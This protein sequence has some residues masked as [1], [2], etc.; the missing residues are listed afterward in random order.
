MFKEELKIH[1][2]SGSIDHSSKIEMIDEPYYFTRQ[3]KF[4]RAIKKK[5]NEFNDTSSDSNVDRLKNDLN[6]L[7]SIMSTNIDLILNRQKNLD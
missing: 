3:I 6:N 5:I 7:H 2:G 1:F 4:E